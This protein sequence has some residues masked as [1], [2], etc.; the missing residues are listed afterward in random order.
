[1]IDPPNSIGVMSVFALWTVIRSDGQKR[2]PF[3]KV[4]P[5]FSLHK[6]KLCSISPSLLPISCPGNIS[7]QARDQSIFNVNLGRHK[8]S[9]GFG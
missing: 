5:F 6:R 7:F 9:N 3:L 8:Y 2:E 4:Q 1:M